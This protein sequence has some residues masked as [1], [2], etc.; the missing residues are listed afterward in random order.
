MP[1]PN[2]HSIRNK[3]NAFFFQYYAALKKGFKEKI[4]TF[5]DYID[6]LCTCRQ[7]RIISN[8]II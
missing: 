5:N 2:L 7:I 4:L 3:S 6:I 1:R 8:N